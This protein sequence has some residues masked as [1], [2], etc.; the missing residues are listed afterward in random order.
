M[1]YPMDYFFWL[2]RNSDRTVLVDCG[3]DRSRGE[4]RG[5]FGSPSGQRACAAHS[6]PYGNANRAS[7]SACIWAL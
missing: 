5:M 7:V 4:Q 6:A 2:A 3:Y 1:P